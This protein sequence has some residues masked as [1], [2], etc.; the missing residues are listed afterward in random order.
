MSGIG[1]RNTFLDQYEIGPKLPSDETTPGMPEQ[2]YQGDEA[3][4]VVELPPAKTRHEAISTTEGQRLRRAGALA[5]NG[6]LT[7]I[8][9]GFALAGL[10]KGPVGDARNRAGM[11]PTTGGDTW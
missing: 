9:F 4:A 5:I 1:E 3:M 2:V 11:S 8:P 6:L 10:S 7:F